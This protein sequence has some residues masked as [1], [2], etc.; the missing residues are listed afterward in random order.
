[1]KI[2]SVGKELSQTDG[3]AEAKSHFQQF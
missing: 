2:L 3:H 1:M